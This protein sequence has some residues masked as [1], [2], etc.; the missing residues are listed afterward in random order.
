MQTSLYDRK[1]NR[2]CWQMLRSSQCRLRVKDYMSM[3]KLGVGG[4]GDDYVHYFYCI[5][6]TCIWKNLSKCLC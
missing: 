1:P 3:K 5:C 6:F 4:C 2:S